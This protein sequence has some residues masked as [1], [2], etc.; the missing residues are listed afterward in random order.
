M[1]QWA[2]LTDTKIQGSHLEI[3]YLNQIWN[4]GQVYKTPSYK[5]TMIFNLQ[6][7][8]KGDGLTKVKIG[9]NIAPILL[10]IAVK[11]FC[12]FILKQQ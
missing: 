8:Y 9:N 4:N 3:F 11:L 1:L 12:C 7:P 10:C 2:L 6:S 5:G